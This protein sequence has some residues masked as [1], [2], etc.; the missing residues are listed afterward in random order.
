M[1]A[2]ITIGGIRVKRDVRGN[3][4]IIARG[5][6][7]CH[8]QAADADDLRAALEALYRSKPKRTDGGQ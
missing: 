3:L 7:Q 4:L 5:N 1:E 8:I 6:G 2:D